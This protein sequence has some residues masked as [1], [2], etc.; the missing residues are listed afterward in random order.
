MSPVSLGVATWARGRAEY[1]LTGRRGTSR[2]HHGRR[3]GAEEDVMAMIRQV[4]PK[5]SLARKPDTRHASRY[6]FGASQG[7]R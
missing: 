7:I 3:L 2:K 6:T 5:W 4:L 1:L